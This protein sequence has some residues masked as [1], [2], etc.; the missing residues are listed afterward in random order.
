[1]ANVT[2]S[3]DDDLLRRGRT[4]ARVRGTSLNALLRKLLDDTVSKPDVVVDGMV[5]RLRQ[6]IGNSH[7]MKFLREEHHRH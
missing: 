2:L 4:Y 1:M 3:L 7:G 5:E 6:T